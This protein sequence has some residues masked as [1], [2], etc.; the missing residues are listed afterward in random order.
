M[1]NFEAI[2]LMRE[3]KKKKKWSENISTTHKGKNERLKNQL[4]GRT[5]DGTKK[6]ICE[7][8]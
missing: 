5:G 8:E 2:E 3:N 7:A 6:E 1:V 4:V